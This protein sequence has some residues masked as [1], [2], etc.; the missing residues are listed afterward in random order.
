MRVRAFGENRSSGGRTFL[1]GDVVFF[2]GPGRDVSNS[3]AG[4]VERIFPFL[5]FNPLAEYFP[6]PLNNAS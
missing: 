6:K 2:Q 4:K 5:L 3:G 1:A